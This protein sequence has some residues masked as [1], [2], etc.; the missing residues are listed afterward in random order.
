M[1]EFTSNDIKDLSKLKSVEEFDA[2]QAASEEIKNEFKALKEVEEMKSRVETMSM[3][4]HAMWLLLKEKGITN[5]DLDES[6][7][8][9]IELD[10]RKNFKTQIQCP[11]CGKQ[12]QK[13]ENNRFL[14]RCVYC[15]AED[16]ANPYKKYDAI[17]LSAPVPEP[18]VTEE[19]KEQDEMKQAEEIINSSYE[20][21]DVTKDLKFDEEDL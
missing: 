6:I 14:Y 13:M 2:K 11:D 18:E 12:M 10:K 3:V 17:D 7:K 8:T 5:E 9:V 1:A 15:G 21:Y 4:L 16:F 20:P 19:E